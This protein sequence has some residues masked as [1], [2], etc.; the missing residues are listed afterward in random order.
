MKLLRVFGA[1]SGPCMHVFLALG[2]LRLLVYLLGFCSICI[3][4]ISLTCQ[5]NQL[6][7]ET[8]KSCFNSRIGIAKTT[9]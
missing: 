9:P 3:E 8:Q 1:N 5:V 4:G 7:A 2:K 6:G